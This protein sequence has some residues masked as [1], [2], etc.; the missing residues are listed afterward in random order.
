V[1]LRP[2][3]LPPAPRAPGIAAAPRPARR[4][5]PAAA[6]LAVSVAL[7]VLAVSLGGAH[8][9]AARPAS[10][11]VLAL[12]PTTTVTEQSTFSL[13]MH[14]SDATHI[15]FAYFTFCQLSSPVCYMPVAMTD[16]GGNWFVGT[17]KPMTSYPGMTLGVRAGYNVTI[18]FT[19]NT[20]QTEPTVPNPFGNLTIAQSV[21]GEYMFQMTVSEPPFVL[22]G[23]V[24]NAVTGTPLSG[25]TVSIAPGNGTVVTTNAT[26][27]YSFWGLANGSYTVSAA[28][29]GYVT[30]TH[31]VVIAGK[32]IEQNLSIPTTSSSPSNTGGSGSHKGAMLGP[33]TAAN[34]WVLAVVVAAVVVLLALLLLLRRRGRSA[35]PAP[36]DGT[37][38]GGPTP[39][40]SG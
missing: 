24:S 1:R 32:N 37:G 28:A 26:G 6:G 19:D 31:A 25:A 29:A 20:T 12:N 34:V 35:R 22:S 8:A 4:G 33:I 40:P 11:S 10:V 30:T 9:A 13:A 2:T 5:P 16:Q 21:T 15:Q 39:P 14:V 3:N 36:P 7:L 27:T 38:A 17:T 23:V 18:Q